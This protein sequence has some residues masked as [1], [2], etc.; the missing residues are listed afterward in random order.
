MICSVDISF[1]TFPRYGCGRYSAA[2]GSSNSATEGI[3]AQLED[4]GSAADSA[5]EGNAAQLEDTG[6][7][8]YDLSLLFFLAG[9]RLAID[10][11]LDAVW[12]WQ[13][14]VNAPRKT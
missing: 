14:L 10:T 5:A 12:S 6:S 8:Q 13:L 3:A 2:E 9:W 11:A 7:T 4:T 1:E